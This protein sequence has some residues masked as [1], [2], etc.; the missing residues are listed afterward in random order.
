[1]LVLYRDNPDLAIHYIEKETGI[2][3]EK[4]NTILTD[5]IKSEFVDVKT[6]NNEKVYSLSALVRMGFDKIGVDV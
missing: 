5:L 1:M 4:L 2:P 6:Q 3:R